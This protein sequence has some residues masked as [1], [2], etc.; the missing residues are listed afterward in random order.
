M[1]V[2]VAGDFGFQGVAG[3]FAQQ[4]ETD[5]RAGGGDVAHLGQ[6]GAVSGL[7]LRRNFQ[8]IRAH[9]GDGGFRAL[10][11][12]MKEIDVAEELVY[13]CA[14]GVVIDLGR[15]AHLDDFAVIHDG[16]AVGHFERLLLVVS[17]EDAGDVQIVMQAA[18]PAAE[19]LAHLGIE[20]AE[21]F[22]EQEDARL[23]GEGA[24]ERDALA[25][26]AGQLVRIAVA[27]PIE[28]NQIEQLAHPLAD[29]LLRWAGRARAQAQPEGHVFGDGQMAKE[30][31]MLEDESHLA[32]AGGGVGSVFVVEADGTAVGNF[33]AGDDAQ[34]GGLSRTRWPEQRHQL[35]LF[36]AQA[37]ILQRFERAVGLANAADFDAHLAPSLTTRTGRACPTPTSAKHRR[38]RPALPKRNAVV[39]SMRLP[40]SSI[41]EIS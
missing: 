8:L 30:G 17:D 2:T 6:D 21:R 9:I 34:Q 25:L 15:S 11:S 32:L 33:E 28:L 39:I 23:D 3:V 29:V 7:G 40:W 36:D 37:D 38:Q 12:S 26:A 5:G 24:G 4:L 22:V 18:Q 20:G 14:G 1:A 10:G 27:E 35:A 19:F 31:I 16:D 41:R 13:E